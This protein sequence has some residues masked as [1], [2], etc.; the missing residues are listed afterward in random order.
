MLGLLPVRTSFAK[1]KMTLGYRVARLSA[2][3][4]LGAAGT[5]LIGH[6]FHYASVTS[7]LPDETTAFARS[8]DSEGRD[9]GF[10]GHRRG[11][12]SGSFFHAIAGA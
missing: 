7:A 4:I 6:E 1:R 12:V 11:T 3:G 5:K 2:D 8:A 10:S 9:L